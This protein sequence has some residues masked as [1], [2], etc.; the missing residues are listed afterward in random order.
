MAIQFNPYY[1]SG[2]SGTRYGC[3]DS[4]GN[5]WT[6]NGSTQIYVTSPSGV[7]L[8]TITP[9]Q[10]LQTP[11]LAA[12]KNGHVYASVQHG[13][14][15][16][17]A[18]YD[19][20]G[21]ETLIV[22]TSPGYNN[23]KVNGW[24]ND[25]SNIYFL[26]NNLYAFNFTT[27]VTTQINAGSFG[28]G[29]ALAV[30]WH[31]PTNTIWAHDVEGGY[32]YVFSITGTL[33]QTITVQ[34]ATGASFRKI[35]IAS[36]ATN[37]LIWIIWDI[38][39]GGSMRLASIN[40]STYA[41][42][43]KTS[44]ISGYNP[45]CISSFPPLTDGSNVYDSGVWITTYDLAPNNSRYILTIFNGI[46]S[47]YIP[48]YESHLESVDS[49]IVLLTYLPQVYDIYH[50]RESTVYIPCGSGCYIASGVIDLKPVAVLVDISSVSDTEVTVTCDIPD[51]GGASVTECGVCFGTSI[52]P[53]INGTHVVGIFGSGKFSVN[54]TNLSPAVKYYVRVYAINSYGISYS[55]YYLNVA[56]DVNGTFTMNAPCPA[57]GY[58][59]IVP[60][61]DYEGDGSNT[62]GFN[63]V[64]KY[65][66]DGDPVAHTVEIG[67][68]ETDIGLYTGM[69]DGS[70]TTLDQLTMKC[71]T[72][73]GQ[74]YGGSGDFSGEED[75]SADTP[76]YVK[77]TEPFNS[78]LIPG[79]SGSVTL[80]DGTQLVV[81]NGL[82]TCSD[83][84]GLSSFTF[85]FGEA[86]W[87]NFKYP[88]M[89]AYD[90][91]TKKVTVI[92]P[93][94]WA[95]GQGDLYYYW[96]DPVITTVQL[97][98][99]VAA[100]T[101]GS[102]P[103][104]TTPGNGG[105]GGDTGNIGDPISIGD[106]GYPGFVGG[107]GSF[108][109]DSGNIGIVVSL[110]VTNILGTQAT[111]NGNVSLNVSVNGNI[112]NAGLGTITERG[113]CYSSVNAYPTL[114]DNYNICPTVG[115]GNFSTVLTGLTPGSTVHIR[116]YAKNEYGIVYSDPITMTALTVIDRGICWNSTGSP[117]TSDHTVDGGSGLGSFSEQITGLTTHQ[118]YCARA[119]A[120]TLSGTIYSHE[121]DFMTASS[122][123]IVTTS[124]PSNI[125]DTTV[126]CGGNVLS[127]GDGALTDVG[128]CWNGTGSPTI[129]DNILSCGMSLGLFTGLIN[130]LI[131]G[132]KFY[133]K[134]YAANA[135][136]VGYGNQV[137]FSTT[138]H[139]RTSKIIRRVLE[140]L[141]DISAREH[142]FDSLLDRLNIAEEELCRDF[143]AFKAIKALSLIAG[144]MVYTVDPTIFKIKQ[145]YTPSGWRGTIEIITSAE[146][147]NQVLEHPYA[148]MCAYLWNGV[149][150][151]SKSPSVSVDTSMDVYCLPSVVL[152]MFID[153]EIDSQWDK[154][155]EY[156]VTKVYDPNYEIRYQAE[157]RS[158]MDQNIQESVQGTQFVDSVQR[159]I[160][161]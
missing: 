117:T 14:G 78:V 3:T 11:Q 158:K 108:G 36:D 93:G 84:K 82:C 120:I 91:T 142:H 104:T 139:F 122:L 135:Y 88:P 15:T 73:V 110:S 75:E 55:L 144:Q 140:N 9:S 143:F 154:A 130:G 64:L 32:V 134:A 77:A 92:S 115:V 107:I 13:G 80:K 136:G 69:Q 137:S 111:G 52:D 71:K 30:V 74:A 35:M 68:H 6:N 159:D 116:T 66:M 114:S 155:L 124:N 42:T 157:A 148:R 127:Q 22:Q 70:V 125:T 47:P 126:A 96:R 45:A 119:Y 105:I 141:K 50:R 19:V 16:Q 112:D 76:V 31:S 51:Q 2:V 147:W 151:L 81:G 37:N 118:V 129:A 97:V 72:G 65:S 123:P 146:K 99:T 58:T 132:Q 160:W 28:S 153:P 100:A 40:P 44:L 106:P 79:G 29:T 21:A 54:L 63:T 39:G 49:G 109:G 27:Q 17:W 62:G 95:M 149:L 18:M 38:S 12:D 59:S 128:L 20:T 61:S 121:V 98:N 94:G 57:N 152:T 131:Q 60:G 46:V 113:A 67:T 56:N 90:Y 41:I 102:Q 48:V 150:T 7:L 86:E 10:N 133:I 85:P 101:I 138:C 23:L 25:G 87:T 24:G 26:N 103:I 161:R 1:N 8:K 89:V 83:P 156:G 43:D 53:D 33:L 5:L 145:I 34:S 4:N